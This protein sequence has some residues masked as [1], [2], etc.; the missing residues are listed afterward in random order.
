[1]PN[2]V[3]G[4]ISAEGEFTLYKEFWKDLK[5]SL[6]IEQIIK[7]L[8]EDVAIGEWHDILNFDL[9]AARVNQDIP[10]PQPGNIVLPISLDGTAQVRFDNI[11]A[12][13][14]N[15]SQY[16]PIK[17]DYETLYLSNAAQAG[18]NLKLL[19]GKGDFQFP[20]EGGVGAQRVVIAST[21]ETAIDGYADYSFPWFDALNYGRVILACQSTGGSIAN[22]LEVQ[23]SIDQ[24]QVDVT[25]Q[26][27]IVAN[28]GQGVSVEIVARY[29][30]IRYRR[31]AG[32]V[33]LVAWARPT[34]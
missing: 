6:S 23:Q 11:A 22:G 27:T 20:L 34:P 21:L 4:T 16:Q 15:L 8:L 24:T 28:V 33:R 13:I 17:I 5:N 14:F 2:N 32:S 9:S 1:M 7:I 31:L 30:R 18:K 29:V 10:V 3:D 25:S 19:I 12:H 26:F